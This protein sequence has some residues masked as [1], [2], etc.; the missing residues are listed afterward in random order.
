MRGLAP[1]LSSY[2]GD[3]TSKGS[4]LASALTDNFADRLKELNAPLQ[5][6]TEDPEGLLKGAG[7]DT[8]DVHVMGDEKTN[9]GVFA[10]KP[11]PRWMMSFRPRHWI[12]T[13]TVT[14]DK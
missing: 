8:P 7:W 11:W 1:P 9:Y 6:A 10:D 5:S 13:A 3:Y 14:K 4:F 2:T 12:M